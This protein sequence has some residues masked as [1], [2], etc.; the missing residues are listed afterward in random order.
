[1]QKYSQVVVNNPEAQEK[2]GFA[3]IGHDFID[4]IL[5]NP[6]EDWAIVHELAHQW[7]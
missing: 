6:Q 1:M 3:I 7:W 2:Q 5:T 4:P